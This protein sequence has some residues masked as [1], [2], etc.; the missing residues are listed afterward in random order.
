[1]YWRIIDYNYYSLN[2]LTKKEKIGYRIL[3]SLLKNDYSCNMCS[4]IFKKNPYIYFMH[5]LI[6]KVKCIPL[7]LFRS[8]SD[9]FR[10][11]CFL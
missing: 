10:N 2:M 6:G 1:M 4:L 11:F 7:S 5:S 3:S 8:C 9:V